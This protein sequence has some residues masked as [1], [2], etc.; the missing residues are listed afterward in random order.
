MYLNILDSAALW[1]V[2]VAHRWKLLTLELA[3]W[4]EASWLSGSKKAQL[5]DY[6]QVLNVHVNQD[7]FNVIF[8]IKD[9]G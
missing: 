8:Y 7:G 4:V 2:C 6:V 1:E 5:K 3:S 9:E